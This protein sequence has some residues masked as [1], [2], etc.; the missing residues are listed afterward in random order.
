MSLT[1]REN[2]LIAAARIQAAKEPDEFSA[3]FA[4]ARTITRHHAKSFYFS[5]IALPEYKKRAAY[6]IY[7]FCRYADDLIDRAVAEGR[8]LT[9]AEEQLGKLLDELYAGDARQ[10]W[11]PA[12][13]LTVEQFAIPRDYFTDLIRGVLMDRGPVR[14]ADWEGLHRY[15][16]HVAS[17]VGLM[18]SK[19]FEL[20]DPAAQE[21]AI[22]MG[23]AMQLTNILRDVKEDYANNRIYLPATELAEYSCTEGQ[24]AQG[25]FDANFRRLMEFQ[26]ARAREYYARAVPGIAKLADDGSQLTVWI[27]ST[28]YAGILDELDKRGANCFQGRVHVSTPRKLLLLVK[29]WWSWRRQRKGRA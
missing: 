7:A 4:E 23:V 16:Y 5:S 28:V 9:H 22:E 29:A 21:Q 18:M 8:D 12:F 14:I 26:I 6:A 11:S 17:V 3:S 24:I 20:S 25:R 19:I 13:W 1:D 2:R 27:M 10:P 15:C